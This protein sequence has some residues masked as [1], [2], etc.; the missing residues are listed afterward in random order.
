MPQMAPLFWFI[1]F[2]FFS[3]VFILFFSLTYFLSPIQKNIFQIF[4]HPQ[5][6]FLWKW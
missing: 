4:P 3:L 2:I 1:L 6:P 5:A